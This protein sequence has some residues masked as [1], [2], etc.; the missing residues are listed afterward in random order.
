MDLTSQFTNEWRAR[1]GFDIK[2][3]KLDFYEV[4]NPWDDAGA[5]T[6][7]FAEQW[8]DFGIDGV[9][10]TE[11]REDNFQ[12]DEGEGNGTWDGGD[13][14]NNN[15]GEAFTD[16]NDNDKW[17]NF[18]EPFEISAYWPTNGCSIYLEKF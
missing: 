11:D 17:D 9:P 18:V 2:S 6:Q 1:F 7:R 14:T 3:H 13:G 15:P 4:E 5:F 16:F 12:P 8:D 10:F